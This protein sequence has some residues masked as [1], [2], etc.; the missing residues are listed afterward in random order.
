MYA[1]R[2]RQKLSMI[3]FLIQPLDP[4]GGN[5]PVPGNLSTAKTDNRVIPHFWGEVPVLQKEI[6]D[7]YLC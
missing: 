5:L 7:L 1:Q 3:W 4:L 2:T 6:V